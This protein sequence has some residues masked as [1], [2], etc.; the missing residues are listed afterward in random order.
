MG[1][2]EECIEVMYEEKKAFINSIIFI[3]IIIVAVL[4]SYNFDYKLTNALINIFFIIT[5][6]SVI[7]IT[8]STREMYKGEF[9]QVFIY[10]YVFLIT[11]SV[12]SFLAEDINIINSLRAN[13]ICSG[14]GG[15]FI[16]TIYFLL[17]GI[18][19]SYL[20]R[21]SSLNKYKIIIITQ[22]TIMIVI[23]E[24]HNC[25]GFSIFY[26]LIIISL[27]LYF[28]RKYRLIKDGR[29]NYF[30]FALIIFFFNSIIQMEGI[31]FGYGK[32]YLIKLYLIFILGFGILISGIIN[33]LINDPYKILFK[34]LYEENEKLNKINKEI[35][36]SNKI[37]E[38]SQI[39]IRR[40][41]KMFQLFLSEIPMPI[42]IINKIN[43][44]IIFANRS[45][46]ELFELNSIKDIVNKKFDSIIN[47]NE[48][49][50]SKERGIIYS[51][52]SVINDKKRYFEI[53]TIDSSS[54]ETQKILLV[55]DSTEKRSI[56]GMKEKINKELLEE[57]IKREFL[58]NITHDLKTPINVIYSAMQVEKYLIENEKI[59]EMNK[60]NFVSKQNCKALISLTNNLLDSNTMDSNYMTPQ[61]RRIN[62]VQVVENNVAA[63][64]DYAKM[65]NIDLI[66]DTNRDEVFSN[67]D[68]EFIS[69][70]ITNLLSNSIKFTG[71]NGEI[72]VTVEEE[73]EQV[74]IE[75]R[76]NGVG[77]DKFFLKVAF[78]RYSMQREEGNRVTGTGIGLFVVKKFVELQNGKI[79]I[80][81]K[82][83]VGT[84]IQMFFDV[85]E[86]TREK[87][88]ANIN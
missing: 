74:K 51:G 88:N 37:L 83:G 70:I 71:E 3:L 87:I 20:E 32:H 41:E 64:V 21:K 1:D 54:K 55:Y 77:M 75:I 49:V 57:K 38:K 15:N 6:F 53:E 4:F 24:I 69:R 73:N 40:R 65:Q 13:Q 60:Y 56:E 62:V 7:L 39:I 78:E 82:I 68:E 16:P 44:R 12:I 66:F 45:F 80:D 31:V 28:M 48:G 63:L 47:I 81:S 36:I 22:V 14:E 5:T 42:L 46:I 61:L 59:E 72:Q 50:F 11:I 17:L 19:I 29:I 8:L 67:L 52:S 43:N 33:K 9:F 30:K 35:I 79:K 85:C 27:Y 34:N 76:D 86:D 18:P 58:A 10:S 2:C 26:Q 84:K 23:N 25:M